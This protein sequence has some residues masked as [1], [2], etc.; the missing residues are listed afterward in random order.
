MN[1]RTVVGGMGGVPRRGE[2][3]EASGEK[4]GL[5][6]SPDRFGSGL[7]GLF[8]DFGILMYTCNLYVHLM[9]TP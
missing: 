7:V 4:M 3:P 2:A 6:F 8:G 9:Y 5:L 1:G